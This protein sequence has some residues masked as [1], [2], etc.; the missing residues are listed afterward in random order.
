MPADPDQLLD[1]VSIHAAHEGG[2]PLQ[3]RCR[4]AR[5]VSIH[6]AHEGGDVRLGVGDQS[7]LVSI[8]AAH[9]GGDDPR[10]EI[11]RGATRFNPRRPRGRRHADL[12]SKGWEVISFNPRR[13]RGRR[14]DLRLR[15]SRTC[16]VSIHAAH[17]GGDVTKRSSLPTY[18]DRQF[19]STPP[20]RAATS[21][22]RARRG[23][24]KRFNPRRPRGR[25]RQVSGTPSALPPFQSTPPT[26]AATRGR[27]RGRTRGLVS[28]HA[29]HEG[30]DTIGGR[31]R[32]P[33]CEFQSTPPTRAATTDRGRGQ[34]GQHRFNPRRPRGRRRDGRAT[35]HGPCCFN[36]RRPR[37]RRPGRNA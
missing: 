32:R 37:G 7:V 2:D 13:P 14:L 35:D 24:D 11:C 23:C 34:D 8:H 10:A 22:G 5:E 20:T 17:E 16:G 15:T 26:R 36:P 4:P 19:Q 12:A 9:E 25:R 21:G 18:A 3:R 31:H 28:I 30:G 1:E 6:A 29:A 33:R 27:L